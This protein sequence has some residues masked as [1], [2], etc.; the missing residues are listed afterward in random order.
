MLQEVVSMRT[1]NS[2]TFVW[3]AG[4]KDGGAPVLDYRI[5]YD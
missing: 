2:I 4:V 1:D 3:Q 5:S